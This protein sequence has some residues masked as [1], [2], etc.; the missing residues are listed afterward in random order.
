MRDNAEPIVIPQWSR[1]SAALVEDVYYFPITMTEKEEEEE[2][3][4]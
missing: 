4:G 2:R 3:R 1:M